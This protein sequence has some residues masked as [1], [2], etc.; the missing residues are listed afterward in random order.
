MAL[1][2]RFKETL[3]EGIT[4]LGGDAEGFVTLPVLAG[5]ARGLVFRFDLRMRQES[6]YVLG[7]YDG[8]ILSR[9][10]RICRPEWT[11]WDCGTYLGYYTVLFARWVGANGKVVAIEPDPENLRRTRANVA[12]NGF[13][14][15]QFAQAAV[16]GSETE[17][18]F[19][20]SGN[21]NSHIPGTYVGASDI[22]YQVIERHVETLRVPCLSLDNA[23][24]RYQ[25]PPPHLIKLDIEGAEKIALGHARD[26][27][28]RFKPFILLELHNPEC[29]KAAWEFARATDYT[30]VSLLNGQP[31]T[32][33]ERV[34]G[35]ILCLPPK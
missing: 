31:I 21:T 30:L 4:R 7:K 16:G 25:L 22:A 33:A 27:V 29:D 1:Y 19:I 23:I 10:A 15:V 26:L 35:T 9:L 6:S 17:I 28:A 24:D 18:D 11:V 8:P 2:N 32:Q 3:F 12:L 20:V 14:N 34:G 5:P 13:K